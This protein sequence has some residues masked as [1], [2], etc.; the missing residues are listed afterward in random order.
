MFWQRFDNDGG[1][2]ETD[3]KN[4]FLKSGFLSGIIDDDINN[5]PIKRSGEKHAENE[6]PE[7]FW[8][9]NVLLYLDVQ[10]VTLNNKFVTLM[11][12]FL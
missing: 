1:W 11:S 7:N 12:M 2:G 8:V 10:S 6:G 4:G 5:I 9:K 3:S